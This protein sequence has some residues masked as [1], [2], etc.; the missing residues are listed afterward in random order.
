[1]SITATAKQISF[2]EKL[3]EERAEVLAIPD[4]A[5]FVATIQAQR[6]TKEGASSLIDKLLATKVPVKQ[7]APSGSSHSNLPINRYGGKCVLCGNQVAA[8]GGTYRKAGGR[9]ETL[10]LPGECPEAV[11]AEAPADRIGVIVGD[12]PDGY[13]AIPCISTESGNDLTFFRL[14]TNKGVVNPANKGRRHINQVVGGHGDTAYVSAEWARKA[15]ET[16]RAFGVDDA[17]ALYGQKLG[18]CGRCGRTLTDEESRARGIGP[19][20][21]GG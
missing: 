17:A 10:H 6:L 8:G 11:V 21:A 19:T 9:W 1:M 3:V 13:Y 14:S 20:C 5:A 12:L 7:V 4:P 18:H 2:I 15:V 16:L